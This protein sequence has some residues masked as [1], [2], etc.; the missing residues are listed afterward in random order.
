M[1]LSKLRIVGGMSLKI[2]STISFKAN[3]IH[4]RNK[5]ARKR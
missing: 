2:K 4:F 5:E 1:Q 3:Q